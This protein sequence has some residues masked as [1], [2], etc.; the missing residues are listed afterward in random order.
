MKGA[1]YAR[2]ADEGRK[3]RMAFFCLPTVNRVVC[4]LEAFTDT[5]GGQ[6]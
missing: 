2:Y 6:A 3:H 1:L 4:D 5:S